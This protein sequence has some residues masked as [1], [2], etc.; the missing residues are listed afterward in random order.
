MNWSLSQF[1]NSITE[2]K[3]SFKIIKKKFIIHNS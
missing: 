3:T 2:I 1:Q